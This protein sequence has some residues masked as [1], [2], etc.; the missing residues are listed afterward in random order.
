MSQGNRTI[1]AFLI[2][3][4]VAA[5]ALGTMP[6]ISGQNDIVAI[7]ILIFIFYF[8]CAAPLIVFGVPIYLLLKCFGWIN[9]FSIMT[10]GIGLGAVA[11]FG[12]RLP[13][14]PELRDFEL[15][16]SSGA[17]ASFVFWVIWRS[18]N[19]EIQSA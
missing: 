8:Y 12:L 13:S 4:L 6:L 18:E 14:L 17:L 10:T 9:F 1:L 15:F 3:P 7:A 16:I 11:A 5:I 2:A 19:T